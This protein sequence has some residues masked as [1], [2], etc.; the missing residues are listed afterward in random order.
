M[1]NAA[2]DALERPAPA[3]PAW[4]RNLVLFLLT[5]A[6]VFATQTLE[7]ATHGEEGAS[8]LASLRAAF[9]EGE[10]LVRGA[11]FTATL[12]AILVS[13]EFGHY[14]AARIHRVDTSLPFFIPLPFLSPFGTMGA[15]IRM[16][17]VIPTR[18]AL[19]DIGASGPLA[20]LTLAIPL[21]W[22]GAA[23]SQIVPIPKGALELGDS[24]LLKL[25]DHLVAPSMPDGMTLMLSPVAYAAWAGM[26]VTMI[27][28]LPVG[29]LDGGHVAYA[30]FGPRQDRI[31]RN[32]HRAVFLFFVSMLVGRVAIDVH[33]GLGLSSLGDRIQG[34]LFWF[35]WFQMLA[36]LG[37]ISR[38]NRDE[39]IVPIR[40]RIAL[41]AAVIV[42]P[43]I[44]VGRLAKIA[45]PIFA[46]VFVA[47]V[48]IERRRGVFQ[49]HGLFDHPPTSDEPLGWGR[50][51]VAVIT[52][53][54]F[55]AL[56]MPTPF[57]M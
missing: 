44:A 13:H 48:V 9:G 22:Y 39:T 36:I 25:I 47:F 32:I 7:N 29:Q 4:R 43:A 19:L 41:T 57:S 53:L 54:F 10:A 23:H 55:A 30:L 31:A 16:R 1:S 34:T 49:K 5:V 50:R 20:G 8:F 56:F 27:N 35:A 15:V 37:T 42:L 52:L 40:L 46:L 24:L 3:P 21:Y 18:R 12:L 2:P 14:I 33:A 51:V 6:S 26:F 17:G 28:L 45:W 38:K 11:E